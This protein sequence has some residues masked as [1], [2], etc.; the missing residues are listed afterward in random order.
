MRCAKGH[1]QHGELASSQLKGLIA[2]LEWE[3]R[4]TSVA[5]ALVR[6][7]CFLGWF[8]AKLRIIEIFKLLPETCQRTPGLVSGV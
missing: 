2:L 8:G 7:N 1:L 3:L 6:Q 5:C 4:D